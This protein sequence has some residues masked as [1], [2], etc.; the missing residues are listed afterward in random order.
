[1]PQSFHTPLEDARYQLIAE[2]AYD[3]WKQRGRP[4][5]SPEIDWLRAEREIDRH[6]PWHSDESFA[7]KAQ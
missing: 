3:Y 7:P 4:I 2:R 5:G 6:A 1:M